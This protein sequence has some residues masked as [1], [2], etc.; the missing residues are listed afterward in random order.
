M[1]ADPRHE[2][3]KNIPI[4]INDYLSRSK[5]I[6]NAANERDSLGLSSVGVVASKGSD[7]V[8]QA[9]LAIDR[10]DLYRQPWHE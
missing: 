7:D 4:A 8:S 9:S 1:L 6:Y 5:N 3:T 10:S 2:P